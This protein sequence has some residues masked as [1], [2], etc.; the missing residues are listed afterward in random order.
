MKRGFLFGLAIFASV[1]CFYAF[2]AAQLLGKDAS[3]FCMDE[4][5]GGIRYNEQTKKWEGAPFRVSS[6]F[7]LK[8]KFLKTKLRR[9][10]TV[11]DYSVTITKMGWRFPESCS[12]AGQEN[13]T[14]DQIGYFIHCSAL[15]DEFDPSKSLEANMSVD[16]FN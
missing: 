14:V 11:F 3:Y 10:E 2:A 13:V 15:N 6:K 4:V 16:L 1:S 9:E 7:V 5:A 8:M 12:N